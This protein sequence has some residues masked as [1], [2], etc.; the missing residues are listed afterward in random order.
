M[1]TG[2]KVNEQELDAMSSQ[3]FALTVDP[4][5]Q[6][7][8]FGD[9]LESRNTFKAG[10]NILAKQLET[11]P[12]YELVCS[13]CREDCLAYRAYG[14]DFGREDYSQQEVIDMTLQ[15]ILTTR[16]PSCPTSKYA[17]YI[18]KKFLLKDNFSYT[19]FKRAEELV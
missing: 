1:T 15:R 14:P 9:L 16:K 5:T 10:W 8:V 3:A 7:R 11:T 2:H 17:K 12:E 18:G 4:E 19:V 6:K 13:E